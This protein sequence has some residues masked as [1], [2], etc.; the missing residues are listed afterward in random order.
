MLLAAFFGRLREYVPETSTKDVLG[1][2]NSLYRDLELVSSL[3]GVYFSQTS[4]N[5]FC[6]GFSCY[7]F[8]RGA[9]YGEVSARREL[10][11][12]GNETR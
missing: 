12:Q 6:F 2:V 3:A 1:T 10:T 7:P 8:Y 5:Y 11:V 4:V 9:L